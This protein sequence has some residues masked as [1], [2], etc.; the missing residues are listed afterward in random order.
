MSNRL[1]LPGRL[2]S[3]PPRHR[4]V[5]WVIA[6]ALTLWSAQALI[7]WTMFR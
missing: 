7:A 4:F 2:A 5:W 1:H 3:L 6:Y